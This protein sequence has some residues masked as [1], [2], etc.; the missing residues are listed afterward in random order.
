MAV[1]EST[2]KDSKLASKDI[3]QIV[4][5]GGSSKIPR[6]QELIMDFFDGK[7]RIQS[8]NPDEA[9]TVGA[10]LLA[11][12]IVNASS[13]EV[14]DGS[15]DVIIPR[16]TKL[17]AT[18]T[19]A[20]TTARDY[21]FRSSIKVYEGERLMAADNNYLS[22]FFLGP[23]P[24]LP[25]G[26]F[27]YRVTF[28]LGVD[29]I[30]NMSAVSTSHSNINISFRFTRDQ[31][32]LTTDEITNMLQQAELFKKKDHEQSIRLKHRRALV[33]T[34]Y[35][36]KKKLRSQ[37]FKDKLEP[38]SIQQLQA[39]FNACNDWIEENNERETTETFIRVLKEF[40]EITSNYYRS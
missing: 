35:D 24:Q 27:K 12:S 6:V 36:L 17:P 21:Q 23:Y 22:K 33:D 15:L 5:V 19:H 37:I 20:Y 39:T 26:D 2:L 4:L 31:N 10:A 28:S 13:V 11:S 32:S 38:Q 40:K 1:V 14:V 34:V 25:K 29:G 3:K 18:L 8:I 30:L 9:V 7:Q 16:N